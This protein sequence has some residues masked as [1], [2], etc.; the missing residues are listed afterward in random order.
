MPY[1][2]LILITLLSSTA[3]FGAELW[4][5]T[6]GT[7]S[8]CGNNKSTACNSI[9]NALSSATAGD[10]IYISAGTYIED[11]R[12]DNKVSRCDKEDSTKDNPNPYTASCYWFATP[13][14]LCTRNS[15]TALNPI[16]VTAAPG[17]ENKVIIDS[18]LERTGLLTLRHDYV[19]IKN[20]NF[21]NNR[22]NAIGS[23]GQTSNEVAKEEALSIGWVI[24]NNS[25]TYTRGPW[26]VNTAG[27]AMW[28]SKDWIVR[29]NF[30]EDVDEDDKEG[31]PDRPGSCIQAYGVI[32]AL[33][34]FNDLLECG[35]GVLWKDHF[36]LNEERDLV[37]ESEIR[38]NDIQA[39][40]QG[41]QLNIRG[42]GSPE[43][44]DN[45]IHHNIIR[46]F[47]TGGIVANMGGAKRP[48]GELLI[49]N[50]LIVSD[51]GTALRAS[52]VTPI[53]SM[54]NILLAPD[55]AY[56]IT[57]TRDS[58]KGDLNYSENNIFSQDFTVIADRYGP[59]GVKD[60]IFTTLSDWQ[61][62]DISDIE[63]VSALTRDLESFQSADSLI[64]DEQNEFRYIP[65]SPAIGL[66]PDG[67]NAGPYQYGSENIGR[68]VQ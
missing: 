26:G 45:Y 42:D 15:G 34:E 9:Q 59:D 20:L 1:L 8:V 39:T 40:L 57:L 11:S 33:L 35:S 43:A 53:R 16:T 52:G 55:G 56:S 51:K 14:S 61:N 19:H 47:A 58:H 5:S 6:T 23:H 67:T 41:I 64:F 4:V 50:N 12:C 17:S 24:E 63:T 29:N 2:V 32:N 66:M 13:S 30:I 3:A 38:Y 22:V 27:I 21:I 62:A 68:Q 25:I 36:I 60:K 65:V 48:S 18:E 28:S 44:G 7:N 46:G 31:Q 54:G 37:F 10:T 49:E